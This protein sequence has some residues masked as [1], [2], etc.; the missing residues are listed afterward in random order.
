MESQPEAEASS[1]LS[2][3]PYLR[4]HTVKANKKRNHDIY[5]PVELLTTIL[6][7]LPV[8][9]LL[10]FRCVS[11]S[12]R[13]VIESEELETMHLQL[14]KQ[15]Q[16]DACILA[17]LNPVD[18]MENGP[19]VFVRP[20]TLETIAHIPS[21]TYAYD[22]DGYANGLVLLGRTISALGGPLFLWNPSIRQHYVIPTNPSLGLFH[23][24]VVLGYDASKNDYKVVAM[25]FP[26]VVSDARVLVYSLRNRSWKSL[27]C[28][29]PA[30]MTYERNVHLR[31]QIYWIG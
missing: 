24:L 4:P 10:R 21:G 29:P 28:S 12:W 30:M 19:W 1:S 23:A 11:T 3:V 18:G 22:I 31:G 17:M 8:K 9:T 26:K 16:K 27:S 2:S 20:D 14:F 7:R 25:H 5:F 6:A 15:L 13:D